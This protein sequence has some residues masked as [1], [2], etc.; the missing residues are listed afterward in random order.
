MSD[1]D[2]PLAPVRHRAL[3][4]AELE[5]ALYI[6]AAVLAGV[7]G[8]GALSGLLA[9]HGLP[10]PGWD[11]IVPTLTGLWRH[12][13]DPA[14][15]WPGDPRPGPAWLTWLCIAGAGTGFVA[16]VE[17]ARTEIAL[18]RRNRHSRSGMATGTDLRRAGLDARS[19]IDKAGKEFPH[20]A[21]TSVLPLHRR[22]G[23]RGRR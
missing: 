17:I 15:A 18:R 20:L 8:G 1:N 22:L 5:L 7:F 6:G 9:M 12:P 11:G 13:G 19:A 2:I 4:P 3:L 14:A 16:A 10:V 23:R 21:R